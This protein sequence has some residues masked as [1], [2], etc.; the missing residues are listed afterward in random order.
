MNKKSQDKILQVSR[1]MDNEL[2]IL[3]SPKDVRIEQ[4]QLIN[5]GYVSFSACLSCL[6]LNS[7]RQEWQNS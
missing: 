6:C 1:A 3:G 7:Y 2:Q 5:M 4:I